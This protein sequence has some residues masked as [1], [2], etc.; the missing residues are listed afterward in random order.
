M[1]LGEKHKVQ[2]RIPKTDMRDQYKKKQ[3]CF[4]RD[5]K[6]FI[7]ASIVASP[8]LLGAAIEVLMYGIT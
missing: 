7:V 6:W 5:A 4:T 3:C 1:T 8:K 2:V